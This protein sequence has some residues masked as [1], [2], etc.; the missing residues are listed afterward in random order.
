[1]KVASFMEDL[2]DETSYGKAPRNSGVGKVASLDARIQSSITKLVKLSTYEPE[3]RFWLDTGSREL[4]GALGSRKR[5]ISYGK[6]IELRGKNH[7]GKTAI[8]LMLAGMAQKDGAAVGYIDVEQSRDQEWSEKYGLGWDDMIKVYP[9]LINRKGK[10]PRLESAE[11]LF[12]EAEAAMATLHTL[13]YKKQYW[14]LDSIAMLRTKV[15]IT[16]TDVQEKK[17][18]VPQ[19]NMNSN[20]D[21]SRFLSDKLPEWVGLAASYNAIIVLVNQMRTK[22]GIVYGDPTYSPGVDA[23]QHAC[24]VRANVGRVKHGKLINKGKV[25][26]LLTKVSNFKNKAGSKSVQGDECVIKIRW[27]KTPAQVSIYSVEDGIEEIG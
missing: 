20:L 16:G 22:P 19:R 24:A 3:N 4:N 26:G 5:G 18:I 15:A 10:P 2:H 9:K 21:R 6:L 27:D 25:V 23:L 11:E 1:M 17:G 7:G 12:Q 14:I 8:A 13:G